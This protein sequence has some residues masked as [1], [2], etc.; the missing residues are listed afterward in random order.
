MKRIHA[1]QLKLLAMFLMLLDHMWATMIP[2]NMWMTYLGRMAFPIFAFQISEGF[3]HSRNKKAYAKRLLVFALLSEIPFN[4]M[5]M[6]SLF[7]PFHQNVLF[8]LLLGLLGIQ[9]IAAW[10][11]QRTLRQGV[12]TALALLG[13][14]LLG[15]L[16]FVDYGAN[17]VLTV[18]LFYVAK[19]SRFCKTIELVG[20]FLLNQVFF[21]GEV[22]ELSLLGKGFELQTQAFALFALLPIWMYD[23][24]QGKS[25][26]WFRYAAYAFYPVH[27]LLLYLISTY[28]L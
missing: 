16:G 10:E 7:F 20:M 3:E 8:T 19:R 4:L 5:Y 21:S 14:L 1:N 27:M 15:G 23:D 25:P 13:L 11:K 17:G 22:L 9:A 18:L 12:L 2:G 24:K 26:K 28:L 6:G